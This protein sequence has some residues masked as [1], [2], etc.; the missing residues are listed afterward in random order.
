[1]DPEPIDVIKQKIEEFGEYIAEQLEFNPIQPDED[2]NS[3]LKELINKLGGKIIALY[4]DRFI[5]HTDGTIVV[6]GQGDFHIYLSNYTPETRDR[7]TIAHELAHYILHSEFGEKKI[8]ASR[9]ESNRVEWEAN[10]FAAGFLMPKD[11]VKQEWEKNRNDNN[12]IGLMAKTFHVSYN[13]M[14]IRLESLKLI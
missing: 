7:F 6:H 12:N 5:N 11:K 9:Y 1:M 3:Q 4:P 14:R 13:A 8:K 2:N 10:W